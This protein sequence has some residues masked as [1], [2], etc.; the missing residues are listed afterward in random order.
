MHEEK[1]DDEVIAQLETASNEEKGAEAE[2]SGSNE[3]NDEMLVKAIELA[4]D[5]G[6]VSISMLQRR[7]R[8]GYARAGRLVDEM[9]QM[10][11]TGEAEGPTKPRKVLITREEWKQMQENRG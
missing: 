1:Y 6:Q 4:I 8:V 5:A 9:T 3:L 11:I 2:S 7:L 10:G